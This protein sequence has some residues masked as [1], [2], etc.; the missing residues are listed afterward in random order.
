[1]KSF[2]VIEFGKPLEMREYV[3]PIPEGEEVLIKISACG[4]C[5]SDLHLADGFYDLGNGKK[6]TLA[7]RGTKLPFTPGHEITGEVISKGEKAKIN[8]GDK[9]IVFP[10]IGCQSCDACH[11]KKETL[12]ENP[13]YLGARLNGG[14]SDHIIIPNARYLVSYG[15]LD[16]AQAAPYACSGLTAY[17]A[18]KKIPNTNNN[19]FILVIGAGGVGTNG[20][21]L[22]SAV[23]KAKIIAIDINENKRNEAKKIGAVAAFSLDQLQDI[24]E[25]CNGK[26]VGAIDFVG[27][28][29]TTD[30][31]VNIINKGG[32]VVVVGLYGGSVSLSIPLIPMR[33]LNLKG[34]YIG[35]LSELKELIDIIKSGSV[36]L[37]NVK[38]QKLNTANEAMND[39][40]NGKVNGRIILQP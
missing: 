5:H 20:I 39:L 2:Q 38:T 35:E 23:H 3:N 12:C 6:I 40:R 22:A 15:D 17:S 34:S 24:K 26:I 33:S 32:T 8:I 13:K 4:V 29:K 19:E 10:W 18:L 14:Y 31:A 25:F 11:N 36:K 28:E 9:G 27:T 37:I 21:L 7:D 30:F 1:M 16:P